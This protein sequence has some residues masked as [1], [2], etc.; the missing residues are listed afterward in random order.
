[1]KI[2]FFILFFIILS[3][4]P[5]YVYAA[6]ASVSA[7][8]YLS[9]GGSGYRKNGS[10]FYE[11]PAGESG[12]GSIWNVPVGYDLDTLY[13]K[14]DS[15][16]YVT[17]YDVQFNDKADA[18]GNIISTVSVS[19]SDMRSGVT[20]DIPDDSL[21]V[22]VISR[23]PSN[24]NDGGYSVSSV[25]TYSEH[26][27]PT[28]IPT[29]TPTPAPTPTAAP[30]P[31]DAP[32]P[33]PDD[34][35]LS[36][37]WSMVCYELQVPKSYTAT[38]PMTARFVPYDSSVFDQEHI[39]NDSTMSIHE[40]RFTYRVKIPFRFT[41]FDF[42]GVGKFDTHISFDADISTY[43][44]NDDTI[45]ATYDYS[46][47]WIETTDSSVSFDATAPGGGW[48][49]GIDLLNAT[50]VSG[51][52]PVYYYCFDCNVSLQSA[53]M[54]GN[55][56]KQLT[57]VLNNLRFDL[58]DARLESE[59]L[60]TQI[61]EDIDQGIKD[62][63]QTIKD[64]HQE[65]IDKAGEAVDSVTG[66]VDEITGVLS[67]WE[68]FTMPVTLIGQ[69]VEAITSDGSTG[70]TFPSF[71]LKGQQLWPSYT[72]DLAIIAE[73]FPALYNALHVISGIL[74]VIGFLRYCWRKWSVLTG[75]DLPEGESK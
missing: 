58:K 65:E 46:I 55:F 10:R 22:D 64:E 47:P 42:D 21:Y 20:L 39:T 66:G 69:F 61:L 32:E 7:N 23:F 72:F 27:E 40:Q 6:S 49:T 68:I 30:L 41:C 51:D 70:L 26:V 63:N 29:P 14:R 35:L 8:F 11:K 5:V 13:L 71:S 16:A 18:S 34:D 4:F 54:M 9:Y 56:G 53:A 28:P 15:S 25:V 12:A 1:M 74:V 59:K 19:P 43:I 38:L 50:I 73:K 75:D 2:R 33:T 24:R 60:P 48:P 45:K 3:F 37:D 67:S 31:S 36:H 62:T 52:S 57:V 17:S 44:G